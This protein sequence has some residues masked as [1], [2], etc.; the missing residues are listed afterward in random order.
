MLFSQ[1]SLNI[2]FS[3]Y[4]V[5]GITGLALLLLFWPLIGK[6]VGKKKAAAA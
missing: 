2:F 3:N 6:F 1:G 5:G 4:L